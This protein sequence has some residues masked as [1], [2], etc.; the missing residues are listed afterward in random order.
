MAKRAENIKAIPPNPYDSDDDLKMR[1]YY[2]TV[3][4]INFMYMTPELADYLRSNALSKVS[5]VVTKYE[6]TLPLWFTAKGTEMPGEGTMQPPHYYHGLFQAKARIL[7]Q[8]YAEVESHLDAPGYAVGDL[9]Y[10][11]NL[12]AAIESGGNPPPPT[13]G[14]TATPTPIPLPGDIN[15]DGVVNILDFTALSNAFGT[16]NQSSDINGDGIVNI[17]DYTILSNNFGNTGI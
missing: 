10:I 3:P 14:P 17:L 11:D 15:L 2:T 13:S 1:Y 9:Y 6:N 5:S 4:A 8:S 7:K 12:V 16:T